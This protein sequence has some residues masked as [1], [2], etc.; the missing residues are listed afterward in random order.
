MRLRI[1]ETIEVPE[2]NYLIGVGPLRLTI[3]ELLGYETH[4][5]AQWRKVRGVETAWNGT[6][7]DRDR[8]AL[9]RVADA[10]RTNGKSNTRTG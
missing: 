4:H 7:V 1:G 2:D 5:G 9:I 6:V 8:E 3:R 10:K